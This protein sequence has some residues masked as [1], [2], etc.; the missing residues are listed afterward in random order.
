M[1]LIDTI[2]TV[3]VMTPDGHKNNN[4]KIWARSYVNTVTTA[5]GYNTER[6]CQLVRLADS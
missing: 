5:N 2:H 6:Y 3:I 1:Y 4:A